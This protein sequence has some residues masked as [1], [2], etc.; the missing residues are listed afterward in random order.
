MSVDVETQV[1]IARP[2]ADVA[3]FAADPLNATRWYANLVSAALATPPPLAV[4]SRIA[5]EAAFLGRTMA[6]T[7]EVV[8]YEPSHRL[9]MRTAEGPFPME[10]T[11]EWTEQGPS[12]TLMR[13]R[14]RGAPTGFSRVARPLM[15]GAIRRANNRDLAALKRLL[16]S[17]DG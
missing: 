3:A 15:A 12:E 13:L 8:D 9:V 4:G 6:Y 10:T 14:N 1:T 5:F 2:I 17:D 11:Y 16:E 7:Y